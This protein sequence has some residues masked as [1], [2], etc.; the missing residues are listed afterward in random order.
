MQRMRRAKEMKD[1][2]QLLEEQLFH[3]EKK[4]KGQI[5]Q[6]IEPKLSAFISKKEREVDQKVLKALSKPVDITGQY[7]TNKSKN[8][9]S[10]ADPN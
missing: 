7:D 2:R 5:T 9:Q 1:Q 3:R 4:W 8:Y 6:P 10:V